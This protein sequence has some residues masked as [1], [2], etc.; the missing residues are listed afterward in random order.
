MRF[1][2]CLGNMASDN[3]ISQFYECG[4]G[5]VLTGFAK[6]IDRSLVVTPMSE[7]EEIPS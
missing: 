6:R 2:E 7:F 1:E 5:K 3:T 4:P